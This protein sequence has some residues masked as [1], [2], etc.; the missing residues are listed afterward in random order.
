[1]SEDLQTKYCCSPIDRNTFQ[2]FI[3][4]QIIANLQQLLAQRQI[5]L[6]GDRILIEHH[7]ELISSRVITFFR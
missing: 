6:E 4:R 5:L 3:I 1:M 2:I 7:N